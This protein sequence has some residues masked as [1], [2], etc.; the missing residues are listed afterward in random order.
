MTYQLTIAY[1]TKGKQ[2]MAINLTSA[3]VVS[4]LKA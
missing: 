1:T 2:K 4:I 3:A